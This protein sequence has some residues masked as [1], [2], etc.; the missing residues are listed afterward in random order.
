MNKSYANSIKRRAFTLIELL[1]VIAIIAILAAILF[2]VFAQAKLAAKGAASLSNSKQIGLGVLM[3]AGDADDNYPL[4]ITCQM[5]D[6][7]F[8]VGACGPFYTWTRSIFPY[9]K[10]ANIFVD[11]IVG[12]NNGW[13]GSGS[14]STW[15][16]YNSQY[17]Y[18]WTLLNGGWNHLV[19][20]AQTGQSYGTVSSTSISRPADM[21][22]LTLGPRHDAPGYNAGFYGPYI[23]ILN[24][25]EGPYCNYSYAT[26]PCSDLSSYWGTDNGWGG[27]QSYVE[28]G[29]TS[30]VAW[31]APSARTEVAFVDGHS[32][33]MSAGDLAVGTNWNATMTKSQVKDLANIKDVYRWWQY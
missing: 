30:G 14:L 21:V 25:N 32:K 20:N 2:P 29:V 23:T 9:I 13:S 6:A 10:S 11:P 24:T 18:N 12:G 15:L 19:P 3:Y 4:T 22:M 28:G 17:A 27:V 5:P 31:R 1:V 33:S 7:A 8:V 26:N 16:A